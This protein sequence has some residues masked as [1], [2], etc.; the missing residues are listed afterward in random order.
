MKSPTAA[1]GGYI[2]LASWEWG[3]P[4]LYT[5]EQNHNW[6][7]SGPGG[8]I[9]P[10][11]W[12]VPKALK[13][14]TKSNVAN[15]CWRQLHNPYRLHSGQENQKWP[16]ISPSGYTTPAAKW[17]PER[18]RAGDKSEVA[19]NLAGPLHKPY[20]LRG[21]A[22]FQT[23]GHKWAPRLH[24]PCREGG[25]QSFRVGDKITRPRQVGT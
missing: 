19:H 13:L 18:F 10:A 6:P 9:T 11:A 21:S 2:I 14:E 15:N 4:T 25:P 22:T 12:G 3:S 16:T 1:L 20:Q 24:N 17:G 8:Y 7:T 5:G 23:R